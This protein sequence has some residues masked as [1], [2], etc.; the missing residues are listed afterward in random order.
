VTN[1]EFET[2]DLE[3]DEF[4]S[5][6]FEANEFEALF[7]TASQGDKV[8]L[9]QLFA[10]VYP[11]L[12]KIARGYLHSEGKNQTLQATALVNEAYLKLA[13]TYK[14][15]WEDRK[16]FLT[17]AARSMRQVL[18]DYARARNADKRG[19]EAERIQLATQQLFAIEG[20]DR[21][22]LELDHALDT[23]EKIEPRQAMVVNMRYF[24]GLSI[25]ETAESLNISP[26][27]AKR[28]WTVAR[29]W[30][31]HELEA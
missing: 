8:A 6:K 15:K 11:T 18:V 16:H 26:A 9:D 21:H 22:L 28:D 30:L 27:T 25:E 23:L 19:P 12:K 17:I 20:G 10:V 5:N 29:L 7:L 1:N 14:L 3:A 2:N 4:D 31:L 13:A 24:A